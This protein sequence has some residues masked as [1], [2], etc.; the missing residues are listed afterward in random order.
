MVSV[1]VMEYVSGVLN[2]ILI[3]WAYSN[4]TRIYRRLE[5]ISYDMAVLR[6]RNRASVRHRSEMSADTQPTTQ[7]QAET[8]TPTQPV[9]SQ[10]QPTRSSP[11]PTRSSPTPTQ[12]T[13]TQPPTQPTPAPA[14]VAIVPTD[15]LDSLFIQEMNRKQRSAEEIRDMAKS[16]GEEPVRRYTM[17]GYATNSQLEETNNKH[18]QWRSKV[19]SRADELEVVSTFKHIEGMNY[20]TAAN[21]VGDQGH[22]LHPLFV[23]YSGPFRRELYDGKVLGVRISDPDFN[24][25]EKK[26]SP[27]AV[28][29]EV[30]DV[31][32]QNINNRG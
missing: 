22:I 14:V 32:G 19:L 7:T 31:G 25:Q 30:L 13:P 24:H 11:T 1:Q 17:R 2:G 29:T 8:P 26:P 9:P 5:D 27:S 28:V 6:R 21:I 3:M 23:D 20:N 10:S 16:V 18:S 4:F 12:P 15:E